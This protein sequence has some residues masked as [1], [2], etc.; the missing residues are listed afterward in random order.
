MPHTRDFLT[1]PDPALI[2]QVYILEVTEQGPLIR[3]M[4]TGLVDLRGVDLTG[5][6]FGE[7][8]PDEALRGLS[9]NCRTVVG[10]PC[11]LSEVAEFSNAVGRIM[12]METVMLP[13]AVDGGRA[14]RLCTFSYI[15]ETSGDDDLAEMRFQ[16]GN[17]LSWIDIGAGLPE[18]LPATDGMA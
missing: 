11:G 6:I 7:G 1:N 3:F 10:H 12:R 9:R 13:L 16:A 4:G 5:K 15:L 2:S 18:A 14:E 17:A 8:L